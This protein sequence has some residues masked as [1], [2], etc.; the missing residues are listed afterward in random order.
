[1]ERWKK[2]TL[3]HPLNVCGVNDIMQTKIHIADPSF[4]E[5]ETVTEIMQRYISPGADKILTEVTQAG[6]TTLLSEIHKFINSTV[7]K[8]ELP[9]QWKES[10]IVPI[11][12]Q[13]KS[14]DSSVVLCH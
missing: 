13:N 11:Y 10:I 6:G 9:Q 8:E 1:M 2:K 4:H 7:N 14:R 3:T 5:V 12:K